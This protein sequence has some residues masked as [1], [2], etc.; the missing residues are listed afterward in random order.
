G[1]APPQRFI[2][3]YHPHGI[4]AELFTLR[5]GDTE[6]SF[7][8]AYPDS[9]LQPFDDPATYGRSFKDKIVVIEGL[10]LLSSTNGHESAAT[11][12]TGSEITDELPQNSSLDQFL[13]VEKGLGAATPVTSVALAVGSSDITARETL[14]FGA[15]GIPVS[16]I[17]DPVV[18]F[19]YLFTS[20]IVG[21]D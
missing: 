14:S 20:A 21:T 11:I 3:F 4:S 18:A 19:D 1:Q 8:I 7:D 10:D 13:A 12:L 17:I 5:P 15:G 16:K 6:T 2:G 9:P